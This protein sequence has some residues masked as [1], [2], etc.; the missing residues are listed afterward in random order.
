LFEKEEDVNVDIEVDFNELPFPNVGRCYYAF[1]LDG[2]QKDQ[3][4]NLNIEIDPIFWEEASQ[5]EK[6][7]LVFHEL[8]HCVLNREHNESL[9]SE[10]NIPKSIM[11]PYIFETEYEMYRNYYINELKNPETLLTDYLN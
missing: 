5:T 3:R 4:V 8:G 1:Y 6:E 10:Q 11:Y 2:P 9:I 7:V